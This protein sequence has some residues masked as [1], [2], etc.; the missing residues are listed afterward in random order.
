MVIS[1]T[2]APLPVTE[3][4]IPTN[5]FTAISTI[6][7]VLGFVGIDTGVSNPVSAIL[8]SF[9]GGD[10]DRNINLPSINVPQILAD[11]GITIAGASGGNFDSYRD[12]AIPLAQQI[13]ALQG[14]GGAY[15]V[16]YD[17]LRE[18]GRGDI[19]DQF[20]AKREQ[21]S[22]PNPIGY[23][24][25]IWHNQALTNNLANGFL[26]LQLLKAERSNFLAENP[27]AQSA[28][29]LF[30]NE[31]PT[32]QQ[33][34]TN[35]FFGLFGENNISA[36]DNL[37]SI[38]GQT[39]EYFGNALVSLFPST[40]PAT[41]VDSG[42]PTLPPP[43]Q[44]INVTVNVPPYSQSTLGQPTGTQTSTQ[45]VNPQTKSNWWQ[46]F[47]T[48]GRVASGVHS[49]ATLPSRIS[50]L[51]ASP[52]EKSFM[53]P[54]INGG[55]D[56][57]VLPDFPFDENFADLTADEQ[58]SI[59]AQLPPELQ[60]QFSLEDLQADSNLVGGNNKS[61]FPYLLIGLLIAYLIAKRKRKK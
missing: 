43:V 15:Y 20:E 52:E 61:I 46:K 47:I 34:I 13:N 16:L 26:T 44:P 22:N 12:A 4:V 6:N 37:V 24:E 21:Y 41:P 27:E 28:L 30:I 25:A 48:A 11:S 8:G 49:V 10:S 3:P 58:S 36:Q 2:E 59:Y 32:K 23:P 45:P 51:F 53:F 5:P 31:R 50:R 19:A 14:E 7:D 54:S 29:N 1:A 35:N 40:T 39:P 42:N 33:E 55:T 57:F 38:T 18:I 56:Q 9:F 60:A 17:R